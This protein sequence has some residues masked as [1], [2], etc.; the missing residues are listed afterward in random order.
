M[1]TV[2]DCPSI[3]A[4]PDRSKPL[5][6]HNGL[7]TL[8]VCSVALRPSRSEEEHM[9][10]AS[11][12]VYRA[13]DR[14]STT[15]DGV[16]SWHC[17]SFGEHYDPANTS[18][19]ALIAHNDTIIQP[20]SGFPPHR[21]ANVE[22]VSWVISGVLHHEDSTG[23]RADIRPGVVQ[24]LSAG[25]G[26]VHTEAAG[27]STATRFVQMWVTPDRP[28]GRADYTQA[29]IDAEALADDLVVVASGPHRVR[30]TAAIGIRRRGAALLV[31]RLRPGQAARLPD[32]DLLHVYVTSGSV[33]LAPRHTLD[34]GDSVRL[35]GASDL[36]VTGQRAT[37]ILVWAMDSV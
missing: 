37:E 1:N 21:H 3:E 8:R 24:R 2:G 4:R 17:F 14:F 10:A 6:G 25:N 32:A 29:S 22:I 11:I 36:S 33:T 35:T 30:A 5:S 20:G 18:H 9:S 34:A 12:D 23:Q 16:E 19:G 26:V 7:R 27:G 13:T 31:G 15:A 28:G